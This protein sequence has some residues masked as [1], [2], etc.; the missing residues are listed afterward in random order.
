MSGIEFLNKNFFVYTGRQCPSTLSGLK[1]NV[2]KNMKTCTKACTAFLNSSLGV[3]FAMGVVGVVTASLC[4]GKVMD[5]LPIDYEKVLLCFTKQDHLLSQ[6]ETNFTPWETQNFLTCNTYDTGPNKEVNCLK[7]SDYQKFFPKTEVPI[8]SHVKSVDEDN[9]EDSIFMFWDQGMWIWNQAINCIDK[10]NFRLE[11]TATGMPTAAVHQAR[12]CASNNEQEIDSKDLQLG[13]E[14]LKQLDIVCWEDQRQIRDKFTQYFS[15]NRTCINPKGPSDDPLKFNDCSPCNGM[16]IIFALG[17][18]AVLF[19]ILRKIIY[20]QYRTKGPENSKKGARLAALTLQE[21]LLISASG[22]GSSVFVIALADPCS[23]VAKEVT[24]T[25]TALYWTSAACRLLSNCITSPLGEERTAAEE[26]VEV[27]LPMLT[28]SEVALKVSGTSDD[29][30]GDE[31]M[32]PVGEER[33]AAEEVV[34]VEL[35]M[36]TDSEVALKVS[37]TSD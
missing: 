26:V 7:T 25:S 4:S 22:L 35:P 36:L 16:M 13:E 34:E 21:G 6:N 28:D 18:M 14:K 11:A 8:C 32:I 29:E 19:T 17:S 24:A 30:N 31:T 1:D 5:S 15:K 12:I 27:E 23:S 3:A 20:K 37:G 9:D 33:A 10:S 2:L